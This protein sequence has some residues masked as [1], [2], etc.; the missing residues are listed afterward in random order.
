M[1][2]DDKKYREQNPGRGSDLGEE[3]QNIKLL[4]D[5]K[6][7]QKDWDGFVGFFHPFWCEPTLYLRLSSSGS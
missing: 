6:G 3:W 5:S 1:D 2:E 4:S 7:T